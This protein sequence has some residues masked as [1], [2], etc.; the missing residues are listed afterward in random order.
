MPGASRPVGGALTLSEAAFGCANCGEALHGPFCHRCGEQR[1]GP[2]H[3][4]LRHFVGEG[5]EALTDLDGKLPRS[6]RLLLTRPGVLTADYAAGRRVRYVRPLQLFLLIN[7]LYFAVALLLGQQTLVTS[8]R[9]QTHS[10]PYSGLVRPLVAAEVARSGEEFGA[11][12]DRFNEMTSNQASTLIVVMI[13]LF[14]GVLGSI[15][16]GRRRGYVEHLVFA[17]HFYAFFLLF[18]V[19]VTAVLLALIYGVWWGLGVDLSRLDGGGDGEVV[20]FVVTASCFIVYLY[21][22]FR[23]VYGGGPLRAA[24]QAVLGVFGFLAVVQLYRFILFFTT[25][26]AL[27]F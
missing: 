2:E 27:R 25:F 8:L 12:A 17:T 6:V 18:Q 3:F 1:L 10:Q 11:Y 14:A 22:A 26:Y 9:N 5:V 4:S 20:L 15:D 24:G 19:L 13:P 7:L 16:W 21:L 23:R